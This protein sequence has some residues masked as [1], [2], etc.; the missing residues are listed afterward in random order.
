[1][2]QINMAA[3]PWISRGSLCVGCVDPTGKSIRRARSGNGL[4]APL[5]VLEAGQFLKQ[6]NMAAEPRIRA[7]RG[8]ADA[9]ILLERRSY[10]KKHPP[11]EEWQRPNHGYRADRCASDASI[12]LEEASA[13][14]GVAMG[15]S[16]R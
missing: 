3:E 12:L 9:S 11:R 1:L 6:V 16:H 8:A 14:R 7:D 4:L 15:S 5:I 13:A 10:W 2:K